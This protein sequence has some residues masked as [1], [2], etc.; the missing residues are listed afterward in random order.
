M[1]QGNKNL[2]TP[3][4]AACCLNI[5]AMPSRCSPT[6][7]SASTD[8]RPIFNPFPLSL[9]DVFQSTM[10]SQRACLLISSLIIGVACASLSASGATLT[11]T[12]TAP[13]PGAYDIYNFTGA[14]RDGLNVGNYGTDGSDNDFETY[15]AYDRADQGQTFTTG[16]NP[17]GYI[18]SSIWVQ[19]V[20]YTDNGTDPDSS[21]SG[22][23]WAM[24]S[25]STFTIRLTKPTAAGTASFVLDK[26]T[27]ATT[28]LEGWP[29]TYTNSA[30]GDGKWLHFKLATPFFLAPQTTYGFDL[31]MN[32]SGNAAL[33]WLG[34]GSDVF[35]GGTAYNGST[36]GQNGGPDNALNYLVGDRVFLLQL[37]TASPPP[38]LTIQIISSNQIQC[39]WSA[40]N[41]SFVLQSST[42]AAGP[43]S[44]A[45]LL[46]TSSNGTN[47]S[48]D[49]LANNAMFYRLA[50]LIGGASPIPVVSVQSDPDG[51]TLYMHP[52]TLKLQVFSSSI[53]RV[54][55]SPTN[56]IPTNSLVVTASATNAGWILTQN[57]NDVRLTTSQ[58]QVRVSRASGAV[59]FYDSN[60]VPLMVEPTVGGKSLTPTTVGGIN[61]LQSQQQFLL[62]GD[63]AIFG[64]GQHQEGMMNYR[65]T[66]VHLQQKNPGES[67]IPVLLSSHGYGVLWDNPAITDVNVANYNVA[68]I[69]STQLFTTNGQSGGLTGSYYNGED[70]DTF[71]G[72][73]TDAQISF[74]WT[75]AA[76]MGLPLDSYSV[77]WT[78]YIQAEQA[79]YYTLLGTADD[80]VR[81]WIDGQLVIDDWYSRA[82]RTDTANIYLAA[83]SMHSIRVDYYQNLY[84]ATVNLSWILP[85]DTSTI[86]WTSDAAN[87]IDYYFMYGPE[88]DN[89]I[90]GYRGLTG[91]PPLFGK[92]AWGFWQCKNAYTNQ[93]QILGVITNYQSLNIPIDG[94]I[95]DWGYWTPNPWGSHLFDSNRYP[96]ATQMMQT[97]HADNV[98]M[99]ISVWPLFDTN[100]ANANALTA[101]NGLFTNILQ[102][103][104]GEYTQWYDPFNPNARQIYWSQISTNLFSLGIDGWWLDASEPEL[105][106]NWGEF[107]NFTTAAGSGARVFNA[108]PLMHTTSLYQ[109]HRATNPNKR[110]FILTRSAYAGQQRN[111][112]VTWSGDVN[113]NW[114]VFDIQIPAG[115][116]FAASGVPYWNTDTG[117]FYDSS[118]TNAAYAELFTRWFQFSSFCPMFRVHG[119][120]DK[121]VY[122]WPSATQT[123]LLNY[124]KLRYHLLPYIYSVSWMVTSGGYTMMRP[125]M[126]DFRS[127]TG[128]YNT[129]NQYMFGPALMPCPVVESVSNLDGMSS[130]VVQSGSVVPSGTATNRNVYLPAGT[131]WMDFWTGQ[132]YTGGLTISANAPLE[133]MPLYVRAGSIIPYGPDIQHATQSADPIELR[134]YHG[135]NGS[136]TLYEDENDNYNYETG[137]FATIPITWNDTTQTLTIGQR[138]GSFP[139]MLSSRTFNIVWVSSN[140]GTGIATTTSPDK[141]VSYNGNAVT[142]LFP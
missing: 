79:G 71:V 5:G 119:N 41:T 114:S 50:S 74:D 44:Y 7:D 58:L 64:L 133:T 28:G 106:A 126:M 10:K 121:A 115:L 140:H 128:V 14:S 90:A 61:T 60:G 134:I 129:K 107:N 27:Y 100:I 141:T 98:H 142:V 93:Q 21:Y 136:F 30:D 101:V 39:S 13:T 45:N 111:G 54:A 19:H 15:I 139:G 96:N 47:T 65:G 112:A 130:V 67:S 138:Q 94:I 34:T 42:N 32:G 117:G 87:S 2:T 118:P 18:I 76:P 89:V 1:A 85:S 86:T 135:A 108:Y 99:I 63:E 53:I 80:G 62:A 31:T 95:Q 132:S 102:S 37:T 109:G 81:V 131:T 25:G 110:A 12:N 124:D 122:L 69:P 113:G 83:N 16:A 56:S 103:F 116:N 49:S 120:N 75:A 52:G 43:W 70:F 91:T 8:D 77:R 23:W 22:T 51:A 40:T 6:T 9:A 72:S 105:S 38:L 84:T 11:L 57:V 29:T 46:V 55:Y 88:F 20:G 59:G 35:S 4:I 123:I 78:G 17:G 24:A 36:A 3:L 26:E 92:W 82:A 33:E 66:T 127:D 68:T 73:R 104:A 125:L 48:T 97:L 137:G